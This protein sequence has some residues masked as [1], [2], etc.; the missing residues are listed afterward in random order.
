MKVVL[1]NVYLYRN[2]NH[3]I[4]TSITQVMIQTTGITPVQGT[5][6]RQISGTE[7]FSYFDKFYRF[8]GVQIWIYLFHGYLFS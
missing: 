1:P 2:L 4:L 8:N 7:L 6:L 5:V 3:L